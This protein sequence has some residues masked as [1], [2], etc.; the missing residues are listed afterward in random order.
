MRH[1]TLRMFGA[2]SSGTANKLG[3]GSEG[4]AFFSVCFLAGLLG[5]SIYPLLLGAGYSALFVLFRLKSLRYSG[6]AMFGYCGLLC[7]L[8]VLAMQEWSVGQTLNAVFVAISLPMLLMFMA[9]QLRLT[10][11]TVCVALAVMI[12]GR[13]G[14]ISLL[15][16]ALVNNPLGARLELL[17][18]QF[19]QRGVPGLNRIVTTLAMLTLLLI[20]APLPVVAAVIWPL[21]GVFGLLA[22]RFG[23]AVL[24]LVVMNRLMSE[25]ERGWLWHVILAASVVVASVYLAVEFRGIQGPLAVRFG[26]PLTSQKRVEVLSKATGECMNSMR[27]IALGAPACLKRHAIGDVD[28]S[29]GE[30]FLRG[31]LITTVLVII[32]FVGV[33]ADYFGRCRISAFD[34]VTVVMLLFAVWSYDAVFTKATL[35]VPFFA[36]EAFRRSQLCRSRRFIQGFGPARRLNG[37]EPEV[38]LR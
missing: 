32:G 20:R 8:A 31:G 23:L 11:L 34:R 33:T 2:R 14:D 36:F 13:Y 18:L 22:S 28:T 4:D 9:G 15:T 3:Q 26:G 25:G 30:A 17:Q 21:L 12:V 10:A 5:Y 35:F 19:T 24:A 6:R 7:G 16:R 38:S 29:F 27:A 37:Q 1:E